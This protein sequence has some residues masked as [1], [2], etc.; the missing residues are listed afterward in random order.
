MTKRLI[1]K[2][3][4][5]LCLATGILL[6]GQSQLKAEAP[7]SESAQKSDAAKV[8]PTIRRMRS[9][10]VEPVVDG[11]FKEDRES[12]RNWLLQAKKRGVGIKGYL[13]VYNDMEEAVSSGA[14]ETVVK[15]K[16]DR[17]TGSIGD[18]Y[19]QSR[20]L[21]SPT[22]KIS[23]RGPDQSHNRGKIDI[24]YGNDRYWTPHEVKQSCEEAERQALLRIPKHKRG[25][26]AVMQDLRR[27]R[28]E[29]ENAL[30]R[31]HGFKD[32]GFTRN[33]YRN[34]EGEFGKGNYGTYRWHNH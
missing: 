17:L 25:D 1:D 22:R 21:Q 2:A 29:R 6:A 27:Q 3:L 12:V 4:M 9:N 16:L 13:N 5:S 33:P 7:V 15:E 26:L 30:M 32:R 28:D 8:S 20:K 11:A 23:K 18:Q 19:Q 10:R 31:K 34:R 24:T 14:S